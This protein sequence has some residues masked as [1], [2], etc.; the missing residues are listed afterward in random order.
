MLL[1]ILAV[2]RAS[3]HHRNNR[4]RGSSSNGRLNINE[5]KQIE[6]LKNKGLNVATKVTKASTF[7]VAEEYHQDYYIK[8]GKQPYCHRYTKRF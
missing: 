1:V 5:N 6:Q 4:C 8:T 3:R 7:W 2:A